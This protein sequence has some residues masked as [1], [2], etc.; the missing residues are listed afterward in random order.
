MMLAVLLDRKYNI[1]M[2]N[3]TLVIKFTVK[4]VSTIYI[5]LLI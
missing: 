3:I 2:Y 4:Y 5:Y 1:Y